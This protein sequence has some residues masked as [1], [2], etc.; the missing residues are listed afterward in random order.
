MK[1]SI[2]VTICLECAVLWALYFRHRSAYYIFWAHIIVLSAQKCIL[3]IYWPRGYELGIQILALQ[4]KL[5]L[6]TFINLSNVRSRPNLTPS[7]CLDTALNP[8]LPW[9]C[10]QIVVCSFCLKSWAAY[11]T[12]L[13]SSLPWIVCAIERPGAF[14]CD[15]A[16]LKYCRAG[17]YL[18]FL[19]KI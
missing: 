15:T 12:S 11:K 19:N 1:T 14:V 16:Y 13:V 8:S 3:C 4:Q 18:Q 17:K 6:P 5:A 2:H 9:A 10:S 7:Q